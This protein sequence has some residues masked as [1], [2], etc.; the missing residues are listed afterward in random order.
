MKHKATRNLANNNSN[1]SQK[2]NH[3][4]TGNQGGE[5]ENANV[6]FAQ[7]EMCANMVLTYG[8]S[9]ADSFQ[10]AQDVVEK[11]HGYS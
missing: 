4:R 6:M 1:Q 9:M 8:D 3:N 10:F 5:E 11:R 2:R 7:W